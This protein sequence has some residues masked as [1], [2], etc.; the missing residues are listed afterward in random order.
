MTSNLAAVTQGAVVHSPSGTNTTWKDTEDMKRRAGKGLI[1][2]FDKKM[3][4]EHLAIIG[5]VTR[6]AMAR[7]VG[8]GKCLLMN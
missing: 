5:S 2:K 7:H 6:I 3:Y 8:L 1:T 4:Q